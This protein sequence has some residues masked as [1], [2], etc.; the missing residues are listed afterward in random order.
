MHRSVVVMA[1]WL[2]P[3][4]AAAQAPTEAPVFYADPAT[5]CQV[6]TY[7]P[8]EHV[9]VRWSGP[10]VGGKADGAGV[11][12]WQDAGAFAS[13]SEGTFHA[14]LQEGRGIRV[15]SDGRR[16]E[17]EF[18]AGRMTGRCVWIK[19]DSFRIDGQCVDG[20]L[21]GRAVADFSDGDR[22]EGEF[23]D[24]KMTGHGKFTH[25]NGAIQEGEWLDAHLHGRGR[26][27]YKSG[28][29]YEGDYVNG[30][31]EGT[32]V[33]RF[34]N[35]DFYEGEFHNGYP[36]GRGVL[37]GTTHGLLGAFHP[38]FVGTWAQGCFR[39]GEYTAE[40]FKSRADCGFSDD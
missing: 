11:A 13:R 6:G 16:F 28:E 5:K 35:G 30:D 22:Y 40:I 38:D 23:R 31:Y 21:N 14:G 26:A 10:C 4:L 3:A 24:N 32:G 37:H 17:A 12:E 27:V 7:F 18:R 19:P 25:H 2:V 15:T 9:A 34:A 39:Q 33:Y 8:G 29:S 20:K 1:A 36:D